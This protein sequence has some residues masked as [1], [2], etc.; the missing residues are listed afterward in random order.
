M[1]YLDTGE[2]GELVGLH[3]RVVGL[4]ISHPHDQVLPPLGPQQLA[5]A[6]LACGG[7]S[8]K[9]SSCLC[10]SASYQLQLSVFPRPHEHISAVRVVS[11]PGVGAVTF[12]G[13]EKRGVDEQQQDVVQE[14]LQHG[15][16]HAGQDQ[17]PGADRRPADEQ[18]Q[19]LAHHKGLQKL[20]V[21]EQQVQG[22]VWAGPAAARANTHSKYAG[23][24]SPG[25]GLS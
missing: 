21:E 19:D 3:H 17:V 9:T 11:P 16:L 13:A 18:R 23:E 2:A 12:A 24:A 7:I 15:R 8:I 1:D 6:L 14:A 22:C 5:D 20:P 25:E 10:L 4:H